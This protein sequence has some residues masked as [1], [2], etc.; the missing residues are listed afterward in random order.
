VGI[1]RYGEAGL[2]TEAMMRAQHSPQDY[3]DDFH[4]IGVTRLFAPQLS[5]RERLAGIRRVREEL[6][7]LHA[8]IRWQRDRLLTSA[9]MPSAAQTKR[10]AAPYNLLLLLHE[11]LAAEL[12][13]LERCLSQGKSL[14]APFAFGAHI[15]GDAQR[16]QWFIGEDLELA[17]WQKIQ[18]FRRRLDAQRTKGH[19]AR[20]QIAR[21][22]RDIEALSAKHSKQQVKLEQ[23]QSQ[24]YL[25]KRI[26][27]LLI[28]AALSGATGLSLAASDVQLSQVAY[29]CMIACVLLMPL[30][31]LSWKMPQTRSQRRLARL[32]QQLQDLC[33][34]SAR[35]HQQS[36]PLQ[37]QI[38]A[39]ELQYARMMN[40]WGKAGRVKRQ[41]DEHVAEAQPMQLRIQDIREEW[42]GL[43]QQRERLQSKLERRQGRA[44]ARRVG[45]QLTVSAACGGL[46][47][48]MQAMGQAQVSMVLYGLGAA[49]SLLVPAGAL[50]WRWSGRKLER[51]LRQTEAQMLQIH[52]EGKQ[53]MRR[54]HPLRMQVAAQT[55][56]Y[57]RTRAGIRSAG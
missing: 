31:V 8:E 45:L 42:T 54:Y 22:L 15:F 6:R 10:Q 49:C 52:S 23:R 55:A 2:A 3:L 28:L 46:G 20:R 36:Q 57:K 37:L 27:L 33:D 56:Q 11:Q 24:R 40:S 17:E 34:E 53:L 41:L 26:L 44:F 1:G 25:V 50:H 14:P 19:P 12:R 35:Y 9:A 47:Y 32:E 18:H 43:K 39:L 13:D 30:L 38:K 51:I 5:P 4:A 7:R 29:G 16:G 21:T 48:G